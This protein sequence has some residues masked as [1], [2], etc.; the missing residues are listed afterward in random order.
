MVTFLR[1][2]AGSC[3]ILLVEKTDRLYR[4][5]KDWVTIDELGVEVHF[6]KEGVDKESFTRTTIMRLQQQQLLLRSKLD[7]AYDDRLSGR[8]SDEL[9]SSKS[10]ELE[11]ELQRVRAEMDRHERAGHEYEATGLQ[12]LEFAQNAYSLYVTENPPEQARL[13]KTLLS[14][15]TFDRGTLCPTYRKPFDLFAKGAETGDWLLRL[16]S[17]QQ[18]SG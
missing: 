14:N 11:A 5:I 4:N 6:V 10:A 3:R 1:D 17:N 2:A 16:D 9:W 7:R 15:S 8:I 13:V 18:P 12:I